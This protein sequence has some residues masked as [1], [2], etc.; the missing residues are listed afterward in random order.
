MCEVGSNIRIKTNLSPD[1]EARTNQTLLD[2]LRLKR[3][4]D[5]VQLLPAKLKPEQLRLFRTTETAAQTYLRSK[6]H[7]YG[8]HP[9][10]M[11]IFVPL[12][13]TRQE[14]DNKDKGECMGDIDI[15]TGLCRIKPSF[16]DPFDDMSSIIHELS[17]ASAKRVG[18]FFFSR[19]TANDHS[20]VVSQRKW[21]SGVCF[22]DDQLQIMGEGIEEGLTFFDQVEFYRSYL[23]N[24]FSDKY[25]QRIAW[26]ANPYLLKNQ[27]ARLNTSLY[28]NIEPEDIAPFIHAIGPKLKALHAIQ[29]PELDT[30]HLREYLI[31]RRLCEIIGKNQTGFADKTKE[32]QIIKGRSILDTGRYMRDFDIKLVL[33]P[34]LNPQQ[35]D[36]LLRLKPHAKAGE[37]DA[38][39]RMLS[40]L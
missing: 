24:Q 5:E 6:L 20:P 3:D 23:Q 34:F 14:L 13:Y 26:A 32:E 29:F 12:F 9:D 11:P 37:I 2:Q 22:L 36:S 4:R 10:K 19:E 25:N 7:K 16:V 40:S 31:I 39:M 15:E 21:T 1:Q 35:I 33:S 28:S 17:H 18:S 27:F 8:F 38:V 30:T